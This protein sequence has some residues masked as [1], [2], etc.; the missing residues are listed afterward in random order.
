MRVPICNS[1]SGVRLIENLDKESE[2]KFTSGIA[3]PEDRDE[4]YRIRHDVY[5]EELGQ[6]IPNSAGILTDS[7][8][9][10]NQYIVIREIDKIVAFISITPPTAS[11]FSIDKYFSRNEI[12]IRFHDRLYELRLLT[13]VGPCRNSTVFPMLIAATFSYLRDRGA[14][15]VVA[16]GRR[17]ILGMYEK[18]GF[19]RLGFVANSGKVTYELMRIDEQGFRKRS[20][21]L[22]SYKSG[23]LLDNRDTVPQKKRVTSAKAYHGGAFFEAI[24]NRFDTLERSEEVISADVLDA[25]F[26]P[27]PEVSEKIARFL[28][29][30]IKTSPP[31]HAEGVLEVLAERQGIP[32]EHFVLGAGSSDLM[33]RAM[34]LWVEA[35]SRV[36]ILDPT[37]GE[38]IHILE[39]VIGCQIHRFTL[40]KH[41]CFSINVES[42]RT[43]FGKGYDWIFLVNPNSPTGS[44]LGYSEMSVLIDSLHANSKLWVDE[45]YIDYVGSSESV[46]SIVPQKDRVIVCK[47]LS[48][49][50]GLSGLR[51]AYLC[52]TESLIDQVRQVTPPWVLGLPTQIAVVEALQVRDYYED[53]WAETKRLRVALEKSLS[54]VG[55]TVINSQANFLLCELKDRSVSARRL[56]ERCRI[57]S[58][59]LRDLSS[60]G[61]QIDAHTFRVSVKDASTN[62]RIVRIIGDEIK[63]EQSN[64]NNS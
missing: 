55:V 10:F 2:M 17:E 47:S 21:S 43:E 6:H 44:V 13:V 14:T 4:I 61:G 22:L 63:A 54:L 1:W 26:D 53:C 56:I 34:R 18:I 45:T 36:L 57:R 48:K 29:W 15:E 62:E 16:I 59:F 28:P 31:T 25:W 37:Y 27:A 7:L 42:L 39:N 20:Q 35:S 32:K 40:S 46:E 60:F 50:F 11:S 58:L 33:F 23:V 30:L 38:Y 52:G 41:D 64:Q 5:A 12:P 49:C 8:D 24:G 19:E 3:T 9:R 51:V